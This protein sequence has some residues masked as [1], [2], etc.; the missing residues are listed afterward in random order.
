MVCWRAGRS[1]APSVRSGNR[2][3]SRASSVVG[4]STR[5]RAAANSMASGKPSRRTQI[6]ATAALFVAVKRKSGRTAVARWTKSSTA[7]DCA[8]A[9]RSAYRSG[10]GSERGWTGHSC[11]PRIWTADRLVMSI[12]RCGHAASRSATTIAAAITCSKLSS[13]SSS[14]LLR[15]YPISVSRGFCPATSLM[16]N[17]WVIVGTTRAALRT[18][19]RETKKTPSGKASSRL[20]ATSRLS[21]VLPMPPGPVI[22]SRRRSSRCMSARIAAL[23]SARPMS[24]VVGAG[25][26]VGGGVIARSGARVVVCPR[27]ARSNRSRSSA[28]SASASARSRTVSRCGRC[29][30]PRSRSLTARVLIV[31]RSAS[32]SCVKP[33]AKRKRRSR[34]PK[35]EGG[36]S[37]SRP[38]S[39]CHATA[40]TGRRS[41]TIAAP[42][43][44]SST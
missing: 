35:S 39:R 43:H 36:T 30:T 29:F 2:C 41:V 37:G 3:S 42:V 6:A 26:F 5:A 44:A 23:S 21:R 1:Y 28:G 10:A 38:F 8:N 34:S 27:A 22:V 9:V 24:G 32:I 33:P 16:P 19:A 7:A 15:K 18:A 11:S 12:A 20:A 14:R 25:R 40:E 17:A 31:A 13:R 4:S